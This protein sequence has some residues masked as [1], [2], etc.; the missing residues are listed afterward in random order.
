M[1]VQTRVA[2]NQPAK[3]PRHPTHLHCSTSA[4]SYLF[5]ILRK[6]TGGRAGAGAFGK[7]P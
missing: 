7:P 3:S 4:K 5:I 6:G 1:G 2:G